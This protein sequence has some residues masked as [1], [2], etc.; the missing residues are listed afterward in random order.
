MPSMS[1]PA[2]ERAARLLRGLLGAGLV[3]GL[4]AC[5]SLDPKAAP[6]SQPLAADWQQHSTPLFHY[7]AARARPGFTTWVVP[8]ILPRGNYRLVSRNGDQVELINGYKLEVTGSPGAEVRL[9]L[10]AQ[11]HAVE[12]VEAS[13]ANVT[14]GPTG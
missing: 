2:R 3:L 10:P 7:G 8:S 4:G 6:A 14:A 11:Y 5:S 12:A 1:N 9:L 13:Y